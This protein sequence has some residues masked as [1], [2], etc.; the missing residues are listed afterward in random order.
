MPQKI[1]IQVAGLKFNAELNDTPSAAAFLARVPLTTR[2]ARWGGEYYGP[3][4]ISVTMSKDARTNMEVGELAIWPDGR[5][6][7]IFFGPTPA[8]KG[9]APRA[10]APV[11]P[12]G[13]L[14]D[15]AAP[16]QKLGDAV[17]VVVTKA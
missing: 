17:S 11:N 16:L 7:C 1:V 6:L 3:A 12:I 2:M 15:N 14:L 5:A 9:S 4:G 10:V 13:R 8:S